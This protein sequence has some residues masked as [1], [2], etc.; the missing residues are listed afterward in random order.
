M[1][2]VSLS[3]VCDRYLSWFITEPKLNETRCCVLCGNRCHVERNMN[4]P[5]CFA[6]AMAKKAKLHDRHE[7][8][9]RKHR[10]HV[11]AVQH[12]ELVLKLPKGS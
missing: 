12:R 10:L 3:R 4:G 6:M 7:C 11:L 8:L 9:Y 1:D 5:T 2:D